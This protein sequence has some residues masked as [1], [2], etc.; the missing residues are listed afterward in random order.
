MWKQKISQLYQQMLDLDQRIKDHHT[1]TTQCQHCKC[2]YE[3]EINVKDKSPSVQAKPPMVQLTLEQINDLVLIP[4][5]MVIRKRSDILPCNRQG[6]YLHYFCQ[7]FN[8]LAFVPLCDEELEDYY[9]ECDLYFNKDI[10][11]EKGKKKEEKEK[12]QEFKMP[13]SPDRS[14][15]GI[16]DCGTFPLEACLKKAEIVW[17]DKRRKAFINHL[18]SMLANINTNKVDAK[19]VEIKTCEGIYNRVLEQDKQFFLVRIGQTQVWAADRNCCIF[20]EPN[21][22][23]D[24][25][26]L[27]KPNDYDPYRRDKPDIPSTDLPNS[28]KSGDYVCS[29]CYHLFLERGYLKTYAKLVYPLN[30]LRYDKVNKQYYYGTTCY[31]SPCLNYSVCCLCD[32]VYQCHVSRSGD[33]DHTATC[34]EYHDSCDISITVNQESFGN[35]ITPK[36]AVY[37]FCGYGTHLDQSRLIFVNKLDY[38]HNVPKHR[39]VQ[40]QSTYQAHSDADDNPYYPSF[41]EAEEKVGKIIPFQDLQSLAEYFDV[42]RIDLGSHVCMPCILTLLK[43]GVL[44]NINPM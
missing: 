13:M 2:Y 37:L 14:K 17:S 15:W 25:N 4:A 38:N 21:D 20:V 6:G 34:Y 16:C 39:R 8:D 44:I 9:N 10:N 12:K 1:L 27:H 32:T 7:Y 36:S 18:N 3:A 29:Q 28:L 30:K 5:E 33:G 31:P 11:N 35:Y 19:D 40:Y 22:Y 26:Y 23:P 41:E 24:R 42:P 43:A